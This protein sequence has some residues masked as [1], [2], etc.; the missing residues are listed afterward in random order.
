MSCPRTMCYGNILNI[1]SI[2]W[3]RIRKTRE[4]TQLGHTNVKT[5]IYMD[6]LTAGRNA[7]EVRQTSF[8]MFYGW[9]RIKRAM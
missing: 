3:Q 6:I 8:L 9:S 5:H 1:R 4:N 7:T 2:S